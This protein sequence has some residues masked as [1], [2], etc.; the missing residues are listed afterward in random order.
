MRFLLQITSLFIALLLSACGGGGGSAGVAPGQALFT[1][2]PQT[3]TIGVG[4]AESFTVGGGAAPY[5]VNSSN[6]SVVVVALKDKV[7]TIGGLKVGAAVV[8]LRDNTGATISISVTVAASE[9][10]F[11]TAPAQ[12]NLALNTTLSYTVGGGVGPYTATSSNISIVRAQVAGNTLSLTGMAVG[13]ATVT[14]R[15]SAGSTISIS[16]TV[17]TGRPLFTTAPSSLTIGFGP[18]NARSFT[19]GG[20]AGP[21]TVT[22]ANANIATATLSANGTL[23][24][25]G[26]NTGSTTIQVRDVSGATVS[27]GVAVRVE[28]LGLNPTSFNAFVGDV[29]Y[30]VITGGKPPYTTVSGFPDALE[31][32]VG[33]VDSAG[34]F[35]PDPNGSILRVRVKQVVGNGGVVVRDANGNTA[36]LSVTSSAS[37]NTIS[38]SP[39]AVTIP[40]SVGSFTLTLYG[41][42]G[43][44]NLFSSDPAIATVPAS[45]TGSSSGVPVPVT[46]ICRA[47]GNSP[48]VQITAIDQTG[49]VGE[50]TITLVESTS[51]TPCTP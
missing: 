2:A 36:N 16:V 6:S 50:A 26:I 27:I 15:D 22:S 35:T 7:L 44:T 1:T 41:A 5:T 3:L 40:E 31:A 45:V 24:I 39:N 32:E 23:T 18:A 42:Q 37:T 34:G 13:T 33:N 4:A 20:G 28:A 43:A 47:D 30:S 17:D 25:T 46:I 49:A 21:Y 11:T 29:L 14:L 51:A 19:V 48:T 10:F 12:L 8:T 38:L 9:T